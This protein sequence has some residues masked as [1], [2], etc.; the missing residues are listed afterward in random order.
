ML[1]FNLQ[2]V[3]DKVPQLELL[4]T[5]LKSIDIMCITEHWQNKHE[6]EILAINNLVPKSWYSRSTKIRGGCCIL[7]NE[8]LQTTNCRDLETMSM[9]LDFECS[10]VKINNLKLFVICIY[11]SPNGDI[12]I[13]FQK[14]QECLNW[15][16]KRKTCKRV[17]VCG[18][19]N[20]D[21]MQ[22]NKHVSAIQEILLMYNFEVKIN[23]PT[24]ITTHSAT[25]IDNFFTNF[26][27]GGVQVVNN[28][29][30][31]HTY[32]ILSVNLAKD[33]SKKFSTS[34]GNLRKLILIPLFI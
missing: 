6:I 30:S 16:S 7:V 23:Q 31:D 11:R 14:F 15:V 8:S 1:H 4:L 34:E 2:G 9:E 22:K 12:D 17:I 29:L 3:S 33:P 20:I 19:L 13:F 27:S 24:R 5:D 26:D 32:Q 25:F 10:A 28:L 21:F 18:D